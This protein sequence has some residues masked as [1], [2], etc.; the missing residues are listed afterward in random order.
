MTRDLVDAIEVDTALDGELVAFDGQ[1]RLSFNALQNAELGTHVVYFAFD[2][3]VSEGQDVKR[4]PL[5]DRKDLL[6]S[7]LSVTDHVQ[8]SDHFGGSLAKFLK[9]VKQIDG[10]GVVAKRLDKPYEPGRRSGA[11]S[12][13]RI[14]IG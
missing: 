12:K 9:R 3:L 13:M 14:N 6:R 5:W 2:I 4:L 11:W 8:L 1:G 7:A 10:E